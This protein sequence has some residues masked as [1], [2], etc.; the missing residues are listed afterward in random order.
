MGREIEPI[1]TTFFF[2]FYS[3]LLSF[4]NVGNDG[5]T[6]LPPGVFD[7]LA[8]LGFLYVLLLVAETSYVPSRSPS[9]LEPDILVLFL[10][11][12]W[13]NE[14]QFDRDSAL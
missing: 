13:P 6:E 3:L 8:L 7:S 4:R 1:L 12:P 11:S 2:R 14:M 10:R 5:L 9:L